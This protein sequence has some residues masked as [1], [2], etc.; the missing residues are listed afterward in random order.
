M[1]DEHS[2]HNKSN[3]SVSL[4]GNLLAIGLPVLMI[5]MLG[6]T[7]IAFVGSFLKGEKKEEAKT[8]SA[9]AAAKAPAKAEAASPAKEA[10]ATAAAKTAAAAADP[11][12]LGKTT[13]A[14]CSAC[15]G[16][17]GKGL[18]VGPMLMAPS[19]AGSEIVLGDP[20]RMA[21][22]ILKG[23]KKENADFMGVMTPLAAMLDDQK[24]SAVMTYVRSS[25][26]NKAAAVSVADAKKA[27]ERFAKLTDLTGVSRTKLDEVLA[28]HK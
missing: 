19:L 23:I 22:V 8:A 20:N 5:L 21:L 1:S 10:P 24:L 18:K 2:S 6:L 26:G 11:M 3:G 28:A 15:H 13:F 27:R 7:G 14:T 25:F 9:P 17:D 16:M 12:A 4:L